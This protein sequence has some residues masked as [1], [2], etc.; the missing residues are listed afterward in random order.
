MML[1]RA[2]AFVV[3]VVVFATAVA[4]TAT[5]Q[6]PTVSGRSIDLPR[7]GYKLFIPDGYV[8]RPQD[9]TDLLVH[10]H[11][12]PATVRNNVGYAGL[13]LVTL[14]VNLGALSSSYQTPYGD[15]ALFGNVLTE[16]RTALRNQPDFSDALAFDK[17][18]VSSFSAGYG[19]VREILKQPTY[20]NDID[21]MVLADTVYASFTSAGDHTPLDSQMTGF[22]NFATAAKNGT[23]TL[24]LSHSQVQTFTYSNTAE[25][26]DDLMAHVGVTPGAYEVTGLG[27][28]QFYR[29]GEAGNFA[30][31]GA[32]GADANAHS[33]HL[34]TIGQFLH[35]LPLAQVPE[36]GAACVAIGLVGVRCLVRRHTR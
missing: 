24:T 28:L 25:T 27:S 22:R 6:I 5:A 23:K 29:R 36:P 9:A 15:A 31:Y 7:T 8:H 26:A 20:F 17:L 11:G 32:L 10:F 16:A 34:Q 19:A 30:A 33:K 1:R 4:D 18:G 14:T 2:R 3:V 13:N 12:D 21:A 35:D